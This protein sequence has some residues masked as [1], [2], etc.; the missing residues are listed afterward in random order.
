MLLALVVLRPVLPAPSSLLPFPA[1]HHT[2]GAAIVRLDHADQSMVVATTI[3]NAERFARAPWALHDGGQCHPMPLS[4]TLGEHMF[5]FGLLAAP[6]HA[7]GAEPILAYNAALWATLWIPGLAMF[8]LAVALTGSP[9]AA[10]VAGLAFALQPG[11]ITDPTHP[12]VHGDLWAPLALLFLYR[13]L[14]GGRVRDALALGI[15]VA[16]EVGES[17]YA[18]LGTVIYL[19]VV[20]SSVGLR[21]PRRLLRAMPWLALAAVPAIAAAWVVLGPYLVT[22]DAWGVLTGRSSTFASMA[23]FA[24]GADHFPGW[25]VLG[26][27]LLALADRMRGWRGETDLRLPV[28][29]GAL[30]LLWCALGVIR[31]PLVGLALPSPL[32]AARGVIPGL[33][34]VRALQVVALGIGLATSLLAGY[35]VAALLARLDRRRALWLTAALCVALVVVRSYGP[36]ARASFG[37]TLRLESWQARPLQGDVDLVRA[38]GPG[39]IVDVPLPYRE[40]QIAFAAGSALL[41]ASY[42]PRDAAACYNSF[43]SPV[44]KQVWLLSEGLPDPADAA[45]LAALGFATVLARAGEAGE[46]MTDDPRT[47]LVERGRSAALVSYAIPPAGAITEDFAV[48]AAG[49]AASTTSDPALYASP[50]TARV[51]FTMRTP[52]GATFRHPAPVVPSDLVVRFVARDGSGEVTSAA[53]ALLPLALGPDGELPIDVDV[54]LPV[55]AGIHRASLARAADPATVLASRDIEIVAAAPSDLPPQ[56]T[57]D[58]LRPV[59]D[60]AATRVVEGRRLLA[61]AVENPGPARY[62]HLD[63]RGVLR[64]RLTWRTPA[65]AIVRDDERMVRVPPVIP[66][67]ARATVDVSARTPSPGRYRV[68]L[69]TFAQPP[70]VIGVLDVEVRERGATLAAPAP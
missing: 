4:Y 52:A 14:R 16:L 28:L 17:L 18:L 40:G 30:I 44:Q 53:R 37:R 26:L 38:S 3:R 51:A 15:C 57:A 33:D 32:Q 11:R 24:P 34:A 54:A 13:L 6:A 19:A 64:L 45:A 70:H 41:R 21:E 23:L 5:G 61:F 69:T 8:L 35:G 63:P 27:V 65:G 56:R 1:A 59:P 12:Y 55:R 29:A 20:A 25:I 46:R 7:L 49:A 62:H 68:E 66:P 43:A 9:P 47:T 22:R 58:A 39:A 67:G 50:G 31:V 48:L 42:G 36:L 60:A 10:F 2:R